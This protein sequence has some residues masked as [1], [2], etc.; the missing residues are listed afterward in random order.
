MP[1]P[2][3]L[4]VAAAITSV[5]A[6]LCIAVIDGHVARLVGTYETS[7]VWNW[8]LGK[9]DWILL[10]PVHSVIVAIA[11]VVAMIVTV[12]APK[13]RVHA[14]AW[15]L[16]AG[17]HVLSRLA[18]MQLKDL[19]GRMRPLEWLKKGGETFWRGG[20]SFPSGHV[21]IYASILVPLVVLVPR[22]RPL[23]AVVAFVMLARVAVNGHYVSDVVAG[24]ALVTV[25]TWL[26]GYAVRPSRR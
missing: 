14:P 21:V 23:L 4:L 2:R 8:V 6:G 7:G 3:S 22:A 19:T 25:V 24:L 10:I 26:V 1:A 18:M 13:L 20:D 15:M 17:T 12:A 5:L 9:L 11:L 16:V